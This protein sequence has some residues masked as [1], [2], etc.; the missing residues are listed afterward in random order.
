MILLSRVIHVKIYRTFF[1]AFCK[2]WCEGGN[3]NKE[4]PY[5][6]ELTVF[7]EPRTSRI[8]II[9]LNT[10]KLLSKWKRTEMADDQNV[11]RP[12]RRD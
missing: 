6:V 8:Q 7:G 5:N 2:N 4:R 3:I 12:K 10:E 9:R 11:S 1:S